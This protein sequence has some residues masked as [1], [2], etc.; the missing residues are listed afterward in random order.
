MAKNGK[1]GKEQ[2]KEIVDQAI[3]KDERFSGVMKDP[4]LFVMNCLIILEIQFH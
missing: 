3:E 1:K 2:N 4:V